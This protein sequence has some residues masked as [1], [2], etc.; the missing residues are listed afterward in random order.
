MIEARRIAGIHS[1]SVVEEEA[2]SGYYHA[3]V[4][5]KR[6]VVQLMLGTAAS[7]EQPEGYQVAV[8]GSDYAMYYK[9]GAEGIEEVKS[10]KLKVKGEKFLQDGKL[11]IRCGE[12]IYDVTGNKV[13]IE[14]Q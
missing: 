13:T 6:G 5:G 1:E 11:Y 3:K 2:G 10:E 12:Q 14:K 8:K 4:Y 9:E 7:E